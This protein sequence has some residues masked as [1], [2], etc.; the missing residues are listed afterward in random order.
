MEALYDQRGK[1]HAW[2]DTGTNNIVDLRGSHLAFLSDDSVYDWRGNHIG[3][4]IDSCVR[5]KTNAAAYFTDASGNIGPVKPV[6]SVKPVQPVKEVAPVRPVKHVKPVKPVKRL[7][8]SSNPP[9]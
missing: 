1:V 7:S 2:L 4:W 9:F 8:W 6:K 3:W 5:D